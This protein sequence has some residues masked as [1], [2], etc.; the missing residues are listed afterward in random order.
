LE[1]YSLKNKRSKITE[2]TAYHYFVKAKLYR[3]ISYIFL[4][5]GLCLFLYIYFQ[6]YAG[7]STLPLHNP[8][9]LGLFLIPFLP[10]AFL[11]FL[12]GRLEKRYKEMMKKQA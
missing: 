9:I 8:L 3:F 2:K 1:K 4:A 12:A 10:A 5:M 7:S 11:F 6:N